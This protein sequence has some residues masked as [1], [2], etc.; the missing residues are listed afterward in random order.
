VNGHA[1]K[2]LIR[3]KTLAYSELA[4]N[5]E[6]R[7]DNEEDERKYQ[8]QCRLE[9]VVTSAVSTQSPRSKFTPW[10][11]RRPHIQENPSA[12][13]D[14][15]SAAVQKWIVDQTK[16]KKRRSKFF[17]KLL[18]KAKSRQGGKRD[19]SE[20]Q[21]TDPKDDSLKSE[22][23]MIPILHRIDSSDDDS[24]VA[25]DPRRP[26]HEKDDTEEGTVYDMLMDI[27]EEDYLL[28]Q[29][30]DDI[31]RNVRSSG[32]ERDEGLSADEDSDSTHTGSSLS[33]ETSTSS[34]TS[35]GESGVEKWIS[36]D[37]KSSYST[38]PSVR[39]VNATS[40]LEYISK[41]IE[42]EYYGA[43]STVDV[44]WGDPV[45]LYEVYSMKSRD[46]DRDDDDE[47]RSTT[48]EMIVY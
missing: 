1:E 5:Y 37:E 20:A 22:K 47:T 21:K 39:T 32:D 28:A 35:H 41:K 42:E 38:G 30:D 27:L 18:S 46:D 4:F 17:T 24:L 11:R 36:A 23:G 48:S 29:G 33:L 43:C 2:K 8:E 14:D 40:L 10:R 9:A 3:P 19:S 45:K 34:A 31:E 6:T 25:R 15:D 16:F 12:Q 13:A 7:Q 44:Q 26:D